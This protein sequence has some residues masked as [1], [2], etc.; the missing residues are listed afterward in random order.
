MKPDPRAYLEVAAG[1]GVTPGE[2]IYTDDGEEYAEGATAVGMAGVPFRGPGDLAPTP[3][4]AGVLRAHG[5]PC[6]GDPRGGCPR[7][8]SHPARLALGLPNFLGSVR[9]RVSDLSPGPATPG[10]TYSSSLRRRGG[11]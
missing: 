2:V 11:G 8:L 5:A 10:V 4:G 6:V 7:D 3:H 9:S 1:L